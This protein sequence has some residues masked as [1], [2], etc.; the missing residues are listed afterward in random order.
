MRRHGDYFDEPE[1]HYHY[2][3]LLFQDGPFSDFNLVEGYHYG[4]L[5]TGPHKGLWVRLQASPA[6]MGLVRC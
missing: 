6:A 1:R 2:E 5:A 3:L 4:K